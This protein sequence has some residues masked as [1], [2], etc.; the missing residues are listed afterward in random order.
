MNESNDVEKILKEVSKFA[1]GQP[2]ITIGK[3]PPTAGII[4][5]LNS[6]AFRVQQSSLG[7]V[8]LFALRDITKDETLYLMGASEDWDEHLTPEEYSKLIP[9]VQ[10]LVSDY[11]ILLE[12]GWLLPND[13]FTELLPVYF[14]NH[15]KE[16]NL[17]TKDEGVTFQALRYIVNGEEL[18]F[19]YE[20]YEEVG[21]LR[22]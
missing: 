12:D 6:I 21:G 20:V 13:L 15:S 11:C 2:P 14:V 10:K 1:D 18:L 9:E 4:E 8:G 3:R 22:L 17:E 5:K 7:G 16:P 19:D